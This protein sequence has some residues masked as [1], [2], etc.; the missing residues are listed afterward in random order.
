MWP[1]K[2][3][4][5]SPV[6]TI[7]PRSRVCIAVAVWSVFSFGACLPRSVSN[8]DDYSRRV[9]ELYRKWRKAKSASF[10]QSKDS[11]DA[12]V[13]WGW[14]SITDYR[15]IGKR[16]GLDNQA[17]R[18]PVI[19]TDHRRRS[20]AELR[21]RIDRALLPASGLRSPY[22]SIVPGINYGVPSPHRHFIPGI[23]FG[24][25][26]TDPRARP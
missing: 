6:P 11:A 5:I 9:D 3:T 1:G 20:E 8:G 12:K 24:V 10:G 18:G 4:R 25:P 21:H 14:V 26:T 23:N 17:K 7:G 16:A 13:S 2:P 19:V 22:R 15:T